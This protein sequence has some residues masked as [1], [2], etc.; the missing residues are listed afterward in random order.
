G[1]ARAAVAGVAAFFRAVA[2][3]SGN[4]VLPLTQ[5]PLLL[6]LGAALEVIIDRAPPARAR[7][8]AAQQRVLAAIEAGDPETAR[9]WMAKHVRDFRRGFEISGVDL[10]TPVPVPPAD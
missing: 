8:L 5:E 2:A 7:I 4:R 6:L 1:S 9:S 10:D 3:A